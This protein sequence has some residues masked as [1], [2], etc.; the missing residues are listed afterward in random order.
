MKKYFFGKIVDVEN[1]KIFPGRID[2]DKGKIVRVEPMDLGEDL[3][4]ILP[5]LV[6]AH[7]HIE[8]SMLNPYNFARHAVTHGTVATVS[9]PHEI[10]NVLGIQGVDFMIGNGSK[11]P[12]KFF[13]GAPSCVPATSFENAGAVLGAKEIKE[14][15]TRK[16]IKYLS[17]MMN[18][19]GVISRDGE[20]MRKL[21]IARNLQK[22][23][24]G[25]A[26]G[27]RGANL[28]KYVSA[29]I[30]T[31]H[32]CSTIEE[33]IE[34]IERGMLIQ[35]R[36][37]SAAKNFE[38]LYP[39]LI[40]YPGRV[41]LCSDDLHPDDFYKG[42]IDRLIKTGLEKNIPFF[43]LIEAATTVPVKHYGLDVGLLRA[44]DPADLILIDNPRNFKVLETWI[45]GKM[46]YDG[47]NSLIT[48]Q[49]GEVINYFNAQP[50]HVSDLR[51][52]VKKG[53]IRII[54]ARDGELLTEASETEPFIQNGEV[55][56]QPEKDIV[57][58][59][60]LNRYKPGKPAIG[61]ISGFGLQKGA[62]AS[63][64]AHD[65]HNLIAI[66]TNDD[67]IVQVLNAVIEAKGG[68]AVTDGT[69]LNLLP[70]PVAGLMSVEP[71]G[72]VAIAYEKIN[73]RATSLC[74]GMKAPF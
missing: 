9:D 1:K 64:I 37:G 67:E 44:G 12:F 30:Q 48:H 61:F 24:D 35:I 70:L 25:H 20:V 69:D 57:K 10:A 34:K 27:L 29:G 72:K 18:Y 16:E 49:P 14:L 36:E 6:D 68:I 47:K 52:P 2:L 42:H 45:S 32:E 66:G 17:E 7:I 54:V 59:V 53:K 21:K 74:T 51:I 4:Y 46:V 71:A 56:S 13:F 33:A 41:M 73:T 11:T 60:V 8:S 62:L 22:P 28:E 63:S 65:S 38:A 23:I 5:G 39:L 50:I 58:I 55:C 15:L 43:N 26:P 40:R 31:D 3:P 19:P